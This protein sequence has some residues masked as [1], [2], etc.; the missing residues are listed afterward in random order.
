MEMRTLEKYMLIELKVAKM[1]E[2]KKLIGIS[3]GG[4]IVGG[5]VG[6]LVDYLLHRPSQRIYMILPQT[7]T[8]VKATSVA[9]DYPPIAFWT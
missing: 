9:T 2:T 1:V 3:T 5:C 7:F 4:G 6:E 8:A